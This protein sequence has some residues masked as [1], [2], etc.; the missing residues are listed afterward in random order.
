[1]KKSEPRPE[2]DF[3]GGVRGRHVRPAAT[4]GNL[5]ALDPDLTERFPDSASVNEALRR[6][7]PTRAPK[8]RK[9]ALEPGDE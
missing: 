1:M 3:R 7:T 2:Y 4:R 9:P 6:V 5:R 8:P